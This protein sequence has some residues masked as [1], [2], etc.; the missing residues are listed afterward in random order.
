MD[1]GALATTVGIAVTIIGGVLAM[2]N[3]FWQHQNREVNKKIDVLFT[4]LDALD[5]EVKTKYMQ[6][7]R[8]KE[9]IKSLIDGIKNN[10]IAEL[11]KTQTKILFKIETLEKDIRTREQ[12]D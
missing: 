5:E 7:D 6:E 11:D 9:F 12:N 1:W 4:K 3:R 2:M 10:F 8:I